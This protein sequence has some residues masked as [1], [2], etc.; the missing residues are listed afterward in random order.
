MIHKD[1]IVPR[2][3][4]KNIDR[5]AVEVKGFLPKASEWKAEDQLAFT[6]YIFVMYIDML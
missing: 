1:D 2:M 5:L 6:R 4:T 3:S